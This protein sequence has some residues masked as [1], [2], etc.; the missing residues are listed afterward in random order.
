MTTPENDARAQV[1]DEASGSEQGGEALHDMGGDIGPT[2]SGARGGGGLGPAAVREEQ[3][4]HARLDR[5]DSDPG[6]ADG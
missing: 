2:P 5:E 3:E 4:L 1:D 6:Q